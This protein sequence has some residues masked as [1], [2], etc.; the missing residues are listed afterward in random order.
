MHSRI[1]WQAWTSIAW[2]RVKHEILQFTKIL[3]SELKAS[4]AFFDNASRIK[5]E[6]GIGIGIM[7]LLISKK[8]TRAQL[9]LTPLTC[10]VSKSHSPRSLYSEWCPR[11]FLL[12]HI[13]WPSSTVIQK[14][15]RLHIF[16]SICDFAWWLRV[17]EILL[18]NTGKR[19]AII[20]TS[21]GGQAA[22]TSGVDRCVVF[23]AQLNISVLG[24]KI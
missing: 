11:K 6:E 5:N 19:Q 20:S 3:K 2:P 9:T 1:C 14:F 12:R 13:R 22:S 8:Q 16:R 23:P 10:S 18:S 24:H 21:E 15:F 4:F 17:K 7:K